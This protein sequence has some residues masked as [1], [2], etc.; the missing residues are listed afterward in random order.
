MY[1]LLFTVII[2]YHDDKLVRATENVRVVIKDTT[3]SVTIKRASI[4]DAGI[5]VCKATSDIGIAVTKAKL[6]I[7]GMCNIY[8]CTNV[9]ISV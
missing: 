3:T 2:W 5:Y 4:E 8:L 7:V 9:Y 6:Q 1:V